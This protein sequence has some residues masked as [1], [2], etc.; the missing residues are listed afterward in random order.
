MPG[1][2]KDDF[3]TPFGR[4]E[5]LRSTRDVKTL[6]RT[7][8][9]STVTAIT[10]DGHPGQKVLKPGTVMATITSGPDVGKIGPFQAA[11][12]IEIQ[13]I[14]EDTNVTAGE[15]AIDF[16]FGPVGTDDL[17]WNAT[18]ADVQVALRAALAGSTDPR[19]VALSDS[20]TVTGGPVGTTPLTISY[21]NETGENWPQL[22]VDVSGLTGTVTVATSQGGAAGAT[23]GRG[24]LTN[25][26]G[27]CNTFLPW[28]L[29]EG[30][31]EVAVIYEAAVVQS[32]CI[33]YDANGA[34]IALTDPTAAAMFAKK[35]IDLKFVS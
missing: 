17:A 21:A 10:I 13:T 31:R 32:A 2:R 23:D 25:I 14:T 22:T 18:A 15:Y 19:D 8:A 7:V 35:L 9:A 27:L 28:Q 6:S 5:F 29:I 11:G 24:V 1:F 20:I 3:A 26:V 33:E 34:E 30:D 16:G 4:N 12:T